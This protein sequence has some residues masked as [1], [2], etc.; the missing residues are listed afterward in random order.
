M[1]HI[2]KLRWLI[3]PLVLIAVVLIKMIAPD[4]SELVVE[5]GSAQI[6]DSYSVSQA[7]EILTHLNHTTSTENESMN[8]VLHQEEKIDDK[9]MEEINNYIQELESQKEIPISTIDNPIKSEQ[10]KEQM[11]SEDGTTLIVPLTVNTSEKDLSTIRSDLDQSLEELSIESYVTGEAVIT[12]DMAKSTKEGV[13]KTEGIAIAFIL[14]VLLLVFRS[15]VAPIVSILTIGLTYICSLSIIALL[16]NVWDFPMSNV[17]QSFLIMVL[18]GIGTDYNILLFMRFREELDKQETVLEAIKETYRTAGKTVFYS[19]LAVII[20]FSALFLSNFNIFQSASAVGLSVLILLILLYTL[21]PAILAILGPKLFW[22][23]KKITGHKESRLWTF[24]GT[25]GTKKPIVTI[26]AILIVMV[27]NIFLYKGDVSFN[28]LDEVD[29]S[30][31]SVKGFNLISEKFDEGKTAPVTLV[32][33]S[34][35]ALNSSGNLSFIEDLTEDITKI[36]GV[37]QV[38]SAT[39]PQ[40]DKLEAF[41]IKNQTEEV[42]KGITEANDAINQIQSGLTDAS[43]SLQ[44]S[45]LSSQADGMDELLNGTQEIN[46]HLDELQKGMQAVQEGI[47]ASSSGGEDLQTGLSEI[48]KSTRNLLDA[49]NKALT[50]YQEI[51]SGLQGIT[52]SVQP[53]QSGLSNMVELSK[54]PGGY[55]SEL[56]SNYPEIVNDPSY[57]KLTASTLQLQETLESIE[58][59]VLTL[60]T[61][62]ETATDSL[63]QTND[64]LAQIASGQ[65]EIIA[66]LDQLEEGASALTEGLN[67]SDDGQRQLVSSVPELQTGIDSIYDGQEQVQSGLNTLDTSLGSLEEGLSTSADGLVSVSEGLDGANDYLYEL[68]KSDTDMFFAPDEALKSDDFNKALEAYMSEDHSISKWTIVLED[69]PYS[70]EAIETVNKIESTVSNAIENEMNL[71]EARFGLGGVSSNN[72]A[73]QDITTEDFSRT[74]ILMLSGIAIVLAMIYRSVLL[75]IYTIISLLLTYFVSINV[76]EIIFTYWISDTGLTWS[77]PFFSF[78]LLMALGVDYSI[79][80]LMR[81]K[82]YSDISAKDAIITSMKH[83]G[84]VIISAVIILTGTFAA[85]YPSN[86]LT[87]VQLA[88]VVIIGLIILV[89]IVLPLLI[90]SLIAFGRKRS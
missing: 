59:N 76:A 22:P 51:H 11:L 77:V 84:S 40:S 49:T 35:T 13:V 82:E 81:F 53:L 23:T 10:L 17:T 4:Y 41:Y 74:V 43:D 80:L 67:K 12:Q 33:E 37:K 44:D 31:A 38:Y 69:D 29:P 72:A 83:M 7:K 14:I 1:K 25:K 8:I 19:I 78:I 56:G 75:P 21:V 46:N 65:E 20:G 71:G 79:F 6:P 85:L 68:S 61:S 90:P 16:S 73:L 45:N 27:P 3:I 64:G 48:N 24:L 18:F 86:V 5:K 2:V 63:D 70:S 28:S 55:V 34:D 36:D 57:Q 26:L 58:E 50:T 62:L 66:G 32:V 88:T 89:F 60:S 30:Y 87:L 15:P 47:N 52:Q 39:R 42:N 9:N 54:A